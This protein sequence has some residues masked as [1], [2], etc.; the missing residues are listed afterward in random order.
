M[1]K[2]PPP[3]SYPYI[4]IHFISIYHHPLHIHISPSTSSAQ[5]NY[6]LWASQPQKSVTLRPQ[7]GGETT[8]SIRDMWWHWK[9]KSRSGY[10]MYHRSLGSEI[11]RSSHKVFICFV[12]MY[13]PRDQSVLSPRHDA[14]SGC[15]WRN[16]LQ[17]G[18]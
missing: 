16:G 11:L 18:G 13:P 1:F 9:K 6:A 15:E 3:T 14:S 10:C 17:Y 4:T 2:A 5:R 8:K 12:C 7:L